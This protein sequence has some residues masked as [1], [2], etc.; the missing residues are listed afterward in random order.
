VTAPFTCK[1]GHLPAWA[2]FPGQPATWILHLEDWDFGQFSTS[3]PACLSFVLYAPAYVPASCTACHYGLMDYR[4][5]RSTVAITIH[6]LT[7]R[8]HL[9]IPL[10]LPRFHLF[11]PFI[12]PGTSTLPLGAFRVWWG[13]LGPG[14]VPAVTCHL[15]ATTTCLLLPPRWN[16]SDPA[17]TTT[18][19]LPQIHRYIHLGG[20]SWV[21]EFGFTAFD[22]TTLQVGI[23]ATCSRDT[24]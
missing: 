11:L 23:Q 10:P 1:Q 3:S 14:T 8:C 7:C 2:R 12:L 9:H 22:Y 21:Q 4:F 15:P 17:T 5:Y 16:Y 20:I 18:T 6:R 13:C 19:Y 24:F